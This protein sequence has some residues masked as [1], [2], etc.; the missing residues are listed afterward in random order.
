MEDS[1]AIISWVSNRERDSCKFNQWICKIIDVLV[2]WDV[3]SLEFLVQQIKLLLLIHVSCL[4][5]VSNRERDSCKFNQWICKSIYVLVRW[6]VPFLEFL[7]QQIKLL[8]LT[9]A[10]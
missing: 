8:M 1:A 2:R 4:S 5:W 7:V 3:P 6:D 10:T 9:L